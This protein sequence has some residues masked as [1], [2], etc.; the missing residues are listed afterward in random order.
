MRRP[1]VLLAVLLAMLWQS[2]AMAGVGSTVNFLVDL[3]HAALHW[4]E[5]GHHHH[6][7]GSYHLDDSKEAVQHVL[8]DQVSSTT[9]LLLDAPR[10]FAP[11]GSPA[12]GGQHEML[13]PGPAPD[14]LLRPPR[15]HA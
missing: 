10:I 4:H 13:V 1:L 12:P 7:D 11:A 2:L 9:A 5:E 15:P 8:A 6:D 14:G 3:E